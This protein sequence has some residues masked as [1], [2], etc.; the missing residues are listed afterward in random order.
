V[1]KDHGRCTQRV[2]RHVCSTDVP[3]IGPPCVPVP[4]GVP[5]GVCGGGGSSTILDDPDYAPWFLKFK[6][7][8]VFPNGTWHV[9]A[10][11]DNYKPVR[12]CRAHSHK[13]THRQ[14]WLWQGQPCEASSLLSSV[15]VAPRL[16]CYPSPCP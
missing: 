15:S 13:S 7:G 3:T 14:T 8:G 2:G 10:C 4:V 11:D 5:V 9:P 6:P 16:P 1:L 12:Q